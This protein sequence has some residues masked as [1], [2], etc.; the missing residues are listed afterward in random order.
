VGEDP[1]AQR[2]H[3]LAQAAVDPDMLRFAPLLNAII[4][5]DL[6]DTH[7]T[8]E[9]S[10]TALAENLQQLVL[11]FL[12]EAAGRGPLMLVLEDAHWLD[13]ASWVLLHHVLAHVEPVLVVLATRSL[14]DLAPMEN[15]LLKNHVGAAWLKLSSMPVDDARQLVCQRLG[16]AALPEPM[17]KLI[18]DKAEG[19][20]F[21]SVELAYAIR[22]A[23]LITISEGECHLTGVPGDLDRLDLPNTVEGVITSRIDRLTPE[24]QL[25][26]KVASVIGPVFGL[27]LLQ[28]IYPIFED[29]PH[30]GGHL[31]ELSR[32]DI[33]LQEAIEPEPV[34]AFKHAIT[35]QVVYNLML[36]SQRQQL[37][38]A[39]ATHYEAVHAGDLAP[40]FS[41]LAYH[42]SKA[43]APGRA[44]AYLERAGD[45]ALQNGAYQMAAR[46]YGE[47]LEVDV[48]AGVAQQ[49]PGRDSAWRAKLERQTGQALLRTGQL[50]EAQTH[51]EA[52]L[53][54]L[55]IGMSVH[56]VRLVIAIGRQ[57]WTQAV[58]TVVG[59]GFRRRKLSP[60]NAVTGRE[61]MSVLAS[62]VE[63]AWFGGFSAR[64]LHAALC[65]LN[66]A[67]RLESDAERALAA[68]WM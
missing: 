19:Q 49:D 66:Q 34:F 35:R 5:L 16:I 51:L 45:H 40:Y 4:P 56:G 6:P 65:A 43:D 39:I 63:L 36:F 12:Q 23:G 3:L 68:A 50:P 24:Q 13:S 9:I 17:A 38:H 21:F 61:R 22:E 29:R 7:E 31:E 26:L 1:V 33:T 14:Y 57:A 32:L 55:G 44:V 41:L 59:T 10:G 18:R 28:R 52:A 11:Y 2:A 30:L 60:D 46:A 8:S 42:W 48:R 20:P 64:S 54:L 62:L 27:D 67:N 53:R 37:H 47:A 15:A 58:H 25:T